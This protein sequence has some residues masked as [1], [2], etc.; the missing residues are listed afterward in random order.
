MPLIRGYSTL[1]PSLGKSGSINMHEYANR[2]GL[3]PRPPTLL[4][5]HFTAEQ[6]VCIRM[7]SQGNTGEIQPYSS[8]GLRRRVCSA[9]KASTSRRFRMESVV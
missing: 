6:V 2:T 3:G 8:V 7:A 1:P 4:A 5:S 9:P